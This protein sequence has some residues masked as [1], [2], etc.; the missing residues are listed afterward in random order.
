M[1]KLTFRRNGHLLLFGL[2]ADLFWAHRTNDSSRVTHAD[3]Q[4]GGGQAERCLMDIT[5]VLHG[6]NVPADHPDWERALLGELA[7]L[8]IDT[9]PNA[10]PVRFV[11]QLERR[12]VVIPFCRREAA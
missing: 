6:L 10:R 7:Q 5:Y 3:S 12:G 4:R 11:E 2:T 1:W 9:V 8:E